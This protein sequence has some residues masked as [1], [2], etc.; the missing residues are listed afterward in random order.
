MAAGAARH[1]A[2]KPPRGITANVLQALGVAGGGLLAVTALTVMV[3]GPAA[4]DTDRTALPAG[5][6]PVTQ[7][8]T[9]DF[10]GTTVPTSGPR[11]GATVSIWST[12]RVDGLPPI[13]PTAPPTTLA[14]T[15]TADPTPTPTA[16][17]AES[18]TPPPS[19]A[20]PAPTP[21]TSTPAPT[22]PQ[23]SPTPA[24]TPTPDPASDLAPGDAPVREVPGSPHAAPGVPHAVLVV[25]HAPTPAHPAG[26]QGH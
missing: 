13:G 6:T 23:P 25:P 22:N 9:P 7:G 11:G 8:R 18:P 3:G 14:P 2:Q 4:P 12:A 20:P 21:T 1:G 16:S 24:P 15:P 19:T 17:P 10:H 26:G 5:T